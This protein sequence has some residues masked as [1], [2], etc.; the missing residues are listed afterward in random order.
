MDKLDRF[1]LLHR[2]FRSHRKPIPIKKL[3]EKLECT[4][5]TVKRII[6]QMKIYFAAPIEYLPNANGWQY[7]EK[8]KDLYELPGLWLTSHELQ[9]L[10]LLLQ[11]LEQ[12]GSGLLNEELTVV[13]K[14]INKL[15]TARNISRA[16]FD[17]HIK[18]LP[19]NNSYIASTLFAQVCE[20]TIKRKQLT[21]RYKSYNHKVSTRCISPQTLTY[22]RE[23]WRLDAY[24]HYRNELRTFSLA[25]IEWLQPEKEKAQQISQAKLKQHFTHSYGIFSG[26]GK[27]TAKLRFY[28][29][30]AREIAMQQWHPE[31]VGEWDGNDYLLSFNYSDDRELV[32]DILRHT[33]NV[34]VE[35][36]ASLRKAV[37][38][39]LHQ[40]LTLM[41]G[42]DIGWL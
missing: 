4:E 32:Q 14:Q 36:P 11:L 1:Q 10:A 42:K 28:P 26:Q 17:Q 38:T 24:C 21:I 40:G 7:T 41:S 27:H 5:G 3:A 23:N 15:L 18:V 2:Q 19:L 6:E 33:P 13:D 25:R 29:K 12:F 16:D 22:Y 34:Y 8:N 30:I 35:A 9:S 39:K 20:A 31:Q 37:Q